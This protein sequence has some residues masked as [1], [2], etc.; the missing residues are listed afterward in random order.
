AAPEH[1]D[2]PAD[3][4]FGIHA[5]HDPVRVRTWRADHAA[6]RR[7]LARSHAPLRAAWLGV[8]RCRHPAR[9]TLVVVGARLGRLLGLGP[10]RERLAAPVADRDGLPP[11]VDDP[12]EARHAP[13][14]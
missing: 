1:D 8:P 14:L 13:R 10:G 7:R 5:G 2:P 9:G 4:L 12:G 11:L 3:A 6:A